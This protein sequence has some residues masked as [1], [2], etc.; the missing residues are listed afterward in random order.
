MNRGMFKI[1]FVRIPC[2]YCLCFRDTESGSVL[3]GIH[4]D[5]FFV[6]ACDLLQML[7]FKSELSAIWE[8]K[9]LREDKFCVGVTIKHNL[10]NKYIYLSQTA[11]INK[12]LEQSNMIDYNPVSTSME[13][14]LILSHHSDTPLT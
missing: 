6:A 9:D 8:I 2:E 5:D 10:V 3:T 11:L 14:G 4:I 13:A 12:I 7:T 1:G